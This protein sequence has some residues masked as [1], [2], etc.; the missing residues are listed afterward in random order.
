LA[1]GLA[2][3][4][5]AV[6][7]FEQALTEAETLADPAQRQVI[8]AALGQAYL[9][10][11]HFGQAIDALRAALDLIKMGHSQVNQSV[12]I[13]NLSQALLIA[14]R[15]DELLAL[16]EEVKADSRPEDAVNATF[17][18]GIALSHSRSDLTGAIAY[19]QKA[20]ALLRQAGQSSQPAGQS[21]EPSVE[22]RVTLDQI[23]F[24][25][26]NISARRGDLPAAI[27]HY[28]DGLEVTRGM[29][30]DVALRAHILFYNNLAYHLHLQHDPA[31]AEYAHQGLALAQEKG[32][33]SMLP[34]LWSTLGEIA[35]AQNDLT[36][37]EQHFKE[38]LALA[39][40]FSLPERIAGLTAN[41]GLAAKQRGHHELAVEHLS[42]ALAQAESL[43]IRFL[44]TQIRVWLAPLLPPA[45]AH[46]HLV[47]ARATAEQ[48]GYE[49]LLAEAV[50]LETEEQ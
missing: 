5:E 24:E 25:L 45:E 35:L 39:R 16:A 19:I 27:R 29:E 10:A 33:L 47:T 11:G 15:F 30:S 22:G 12:L 49:G 42:A 36:A 17:L 37:A 6:A 18:Y 20:E 14:T 8:L 31:A 48:D 44:A 23:K 32:V 7:F 40:Q 2:A 43:N 34:Y 1:T 26:G 50:R 28:R 4:N 9:Q 38:G 3:W 13:M 46:P 21:P 41:L